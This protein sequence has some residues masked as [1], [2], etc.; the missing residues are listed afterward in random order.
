VLSEIR[1]NEIAKHPICTIHAKEPKTFA[2][3]ENA[4]GINI[5]RHNLR[6]IMEAL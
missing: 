4:I 2:A 3:D 5:K 6:K 1:V